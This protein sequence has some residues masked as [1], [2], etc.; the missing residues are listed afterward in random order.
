MDVQI[1]N[2]VI[3]EP[4]AL[5]TTTNK[6]CSQNCEF[7]PYFPAEKKLEYKNAHELFGTPSIMKMMRFAPTT[8]EKCILAS[9]ILTEGKAWK[10]YPAKGGFETIRKLKWEI[11]QRKLYLNKLK[12]KMKVVEEETKIM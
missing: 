5:C 6:T 8:E 4:C 1:I 11:L 9:S 7:A 3:R 2:V 12:E 10:D